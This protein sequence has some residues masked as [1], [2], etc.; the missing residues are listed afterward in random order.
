MIDDMSLKNKSVLRL[1]LN[2]EMFSCH[3]IF[4]FYY[5]RSIDFVHIALLRISNNLFE[6]FSFLKLI[7]LSIIWY[8]NYSTE[9]NYN[10]QRK[11]VWHGVALNINTCTLCQDTDLYSPLLILHTLT[12]I[13]CYNAADICWP[14]EPIN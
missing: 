4:A 5:F 1:T 6:V 3:T 12:R 8:C 14:W 2:V 13:F 7:K 10:I 11:I 9:I